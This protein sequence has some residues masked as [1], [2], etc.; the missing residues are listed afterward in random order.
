MRRIL[1]GVGII[2]AT[3]SD[4][5]QTSGGPISRA[6]LTVINCLK[7][8]FNPEL[9]AQEIVDV[10]QNSSV[11]FLKSFWRL[12]ESQFM[13]T[14]PRW[15][16]PKF[17]VR[18]EILVPDQ[19]IVLRNILSG[20]LVTIP[21]PSS[22]IPPAP[23]RCILMS[24]LLRKGQMANKYKFY[25]EE[26]LS[27]SILF[28][29]HGG[30]FISQ[31]PESHEIY[32]RHWA[33]DL[34]VPIFSVDYSLS[35]EAPFP[36][37]LEEVLLA[38]AWVLQNPQRL[39]WTGERIC[40]AGD[41]AGGNILLGIILKTISLGIRKP[42]AVLCAYSPLVLDMVPS[43][44]RLLCWID[45]L[46]PLGFMLSCLDAYGGS[47]QTDGNEYDEEP[48]QE[49]S[50]R[51]SRKISSISEIF[52]SSMNFIKQSEWMEV[53]ANEPSV[54]DEDSA[55]CSDKKQKL[56]KETNYV[57]QFMD[58]YS[59]V[60]FNETNEEMRD[61]KEH[62][63]FSVPHDIVFDLKTK[64][65]SVADSTLQMVSE[66]LISSSLYQKFIAPFVPYKK[67]QNL[68]INK[69]SDAKVSINEKMK[70]LKMVSR[71]PFMSPLLASDENLKEMPQIF[72]VT[73]NFDP[74][75]DD[76]ITFAK[77]LTEL[78][79]PVEVDVLDGLPHG[80]LNFLPFSKEAHDGSDQCVRR[81]K[82]AL[83]IS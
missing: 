34:N 41:S 72:F 66:T 54:V 24:T 47:M 9:R 76:T 22:H 3:F 25:K 43:P 1:Q 44:S 11:E 26:E 23:V 30:G 27:P 40:F 38:Y 6:A 2:M 75:L 59:A 14:L 46:L 20:V 18:E 71:N 65:E 56:V 28:H 77:R 79:R 69:L 42:D 21:A 39:G 31:S 8:I 58:D 70:N 60:N 17:Q 49:L 50:G 15:I 5:Y 67:Y 12:G 73:L 33:K 52:D 63:L 55:F 45:P 48:N 4:L 37:A 51:R 64:W 81:L 19:P 61:Y 78:N 74:C 62:T 10:A 13:T 7:Y 68:T 35:P 80:F 57:H 32:L 29:C 53:E 82:E 36:R 83:L 16:C